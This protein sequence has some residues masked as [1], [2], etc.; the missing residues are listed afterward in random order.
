MMYPCSLSSRSSDAQYTVTSAC[1]AARRRTPS[2][3][4]ASREHWIEQKEIALGRVARHFEVVVDRLERVVVSVQPDVSDTR[5]RDEAIDPLDHAQA[6]AK[7]GHERQLLPAH[8]LSH[9]WLERRVHGHR[10]EREIARCFV[11][12]QHRDLVHQLLEDLRRRSPIAQN[13]QLV[14]DERVRDDPQCWEAGGSVHGGGGD[15]R[16]S[17]NFARMK[18]YQAVIL[19]L[20]RHARD[21]E[22]ALTDLLNERSRGGWAPALMSQDGLR[23]TVIFQR[24]ATVEQ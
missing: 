18:E 14:L 23:L 10:L 9:R 6:R 21:D 24:P 8:A 20:T 11:R 12:H 16:E 4:P 15:G 3:A 5:A 2:G 22:D 19:R 13:R 17:T 7:D 1:D